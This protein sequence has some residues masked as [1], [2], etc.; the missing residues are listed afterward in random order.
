[1]CV[2][3]N[4]IRAPGVCISEMSGLRT[5]VGIAIAAGALFASVTVVLV[6]GSV[7]I[8]PPMRAAP[9]TSRADYVARL[10]D[11]SW[12]PAGIAAADGIPLR[13]WLFTPRSPNGAA[14]I[15]LHGVADTRTGTLGHAA[16][17][18]EHGY[19]VLTP[20]ARGHGVSGGSLIT[21]GVVEAGDLD[22]WAAWLS[23][24]PGVTRLYGLGM[25]MGAAI[26]LESVARETRFRAVVADCPFATFPEVARDRLHQYSGAPAFVTVPIVRFGILY[27]GLR[28]G[29]D[30]RRASPAAAIR[31]TRTPVLLIHG[32]RDTNIPPRH[33]RELHALDPA[34]ELWEVSGAG[35]VASIVAASREYPERVLAWFASHP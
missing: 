2:A 14:V 9:D 17:L 20:D 29:V 21:Y 8:A 16:F 6:E 1:M 22:L 3:V 18:L 32:D 34:S 30:L 5:L 24:Q 35:H 28:Y 26:L 31:T 19:T 27:A 25:S 13:A 4:K 7:H 12:G 10:T 33:S 23:A 15:L 11:S